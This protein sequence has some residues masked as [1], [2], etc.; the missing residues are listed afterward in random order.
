MVLK[1]L[2][3]KKTIELGVYTGYS[4]LLTAMTIPDDGKVIAIDVTKKDY[5]EVGRQFAKKAGVE[6]KI[7]FIESQALPVLDDLLSKPENWGAF[8]FAYVDADRNNALNYHE[9]LVRLV[10]VGGVIIHDN[11]LWGGT[12]AVKDR[13]MIENSRLFAW[14]DTLRLNTALAADPLVEICQITLGDGLTI[15]RRV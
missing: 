7:D 9:R 12:V 6:H 5:D 8:D 3:A 10:R 2:N 14:K 11:T 13:S 1:M 15:C 4:L